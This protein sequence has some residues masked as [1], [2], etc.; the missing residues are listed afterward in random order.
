MLVFS[1]RRL[2]AV[3][4]AAGISDPTVLADRMR[5]VNPL[6]RASAQGVRRVWRG[7]GGFDTPHLLAAAEACGVLPH[8]FCVQRRAMVVL[9]EAEVLR[10]LRTKRGRGRPRAAPP[11]PV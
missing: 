3:A 7:A 8:E 4:R 9:A 10:A 11:D 6:L 2:Q 1:H 5:L